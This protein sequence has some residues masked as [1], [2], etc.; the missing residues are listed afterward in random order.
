MAGGPGYE[1]E[2]RHSKSTQDKQIQ[3]I[4]NRERRRPQEINP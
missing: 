2:K 1:I 3:D 4:K